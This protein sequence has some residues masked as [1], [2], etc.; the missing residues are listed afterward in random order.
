[1][2]WILLGDVMDEQAD[3]RTKLTKSLVRVT[4]ALVIVGLIGAGLAYWGY[5]GLI[6]EQKKSTE[7]E[8][9][10]YCHIVQAPASAGFQYYLGDSV[11]IDNVPRSIDSIPLG[12]TEYMA[13]RRIGFLVPRLGIFI[14]IGKTPLRIKTSVASILSQREW[15]EKHGKDYEHLIQ[16][17]KLPGTIDTLHTDFVLL[18]G[19]SSEPAPQLGYR[20]YMSK[21]E[22]HQYVYSDSSIVLYPYQYVEYEDFFGHQYNALLIQ[23]LKADIEIIDSIPVFS[24]SDKPGVERYRW[25]IG[26]ED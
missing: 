9:R 21:D 18:P 6:K 11:A 12:S 22:W 25:D 13:V 10:P 8:W 17:L 4:W 7:M 16:T 24:W 23:Y 14:N 15:V 3:A 2:L 19:D 1:M 26:L 5:R 20:R